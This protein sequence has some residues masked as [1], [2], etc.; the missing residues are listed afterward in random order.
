MQARTGSPLVNRGI[1]SACLLVGFA[2]LAGIALVGGATGAAAADTT[3]NASLGAD[4]SSFMQASSV[5]T[6]MA[7]EDG[8]FGVA[9]NRTEDPEAR[10]ALIEARQALIEERHQRLQTRRGS[11]GERPDVRNRSIATGVAVGA[12]SL[13]RSINETERAANGTGVDTERLA[14]LRSEARSLRGPEVAELARGLAGPP[15]GGPPGLTSPERGP[16]G[17]TTDANRS[18]STNRTGRPGSDGPGPSGPREEAGDQAPRDARDAE[19]NGPPLDQSVTPEESDSSDAGARDE[20]SDGGPP[21]EPG[22]L[23]RDGVPGPSDD[24]G[25]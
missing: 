9:L 22:T 25:Q 18:A 8:T 24:G 4:I 11:L 6:D 19:R 7:I 10:R 2:A 15:G 5:E 1:V 14:R 23:T 20:N 3:T 16:P 17:S 13:E 12:A 21:N